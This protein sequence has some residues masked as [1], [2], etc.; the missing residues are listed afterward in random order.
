MTGSGVGRGIVVPAGPLA[1]TIRPPG[2]KSETNR[3]LV[4]AALADGD[5]TVRDV[6]VADDTEAMV[7]GLGSLGVELR[8]RPDPSGSGNA[9]VAVVGCAGRPPGGG[10]INA[11]LSG[12]TSRFLIPVAALG[13]EPS[14]VDG[15]PPL[16][17]RPMGDLLDAVVSLG[18][19]VE[20]LEERGHLPVRVGDPRPTGG[21]VTVRGDVSSQFLS[22]LLLAGPCL[23][24]GLHVEVT[25]DLVSV[26]YVQLT[27]DAMARFGAVVDG[28]VASSLRVRPSGY[29]AADVRVEADATAA[30]YFMAAPLIAGGRVRVE[31]VGS[32]SVQ[33]DA[34]F[35]DVLRRM[36]ADVRQGPDWTEVTSTGELYGIEVDLSDMSD[37]AQTLAV[38]AP[39]A[40]SPTTVRGIGFI[41]AKE[42][43]RIAAVVTELQ[44]LGVD[45]VARA[46]GFTVRPGRPVGGVVHTYGDH[47]MAMS[48][49]LIGLAVPG[50]V[51][52]DP[53]CV[54][55][56][57]PRFWDDLDRVVTDSGRGGSPTTL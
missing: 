53:G 5:S 11:R 31:G 10:L 52:A 19:G 47:R 44:R 21:R 38:L 50:V 22:G 54:D 23:A 17:S 48:F 45:A 40:S 30:S 32:A 4:C 42:T 24:E 27:V 43:D 46:D 16:R 49:S 39:F 35:A 26:P 12:T 33:G 3:L 8:V 56:T 37:T 25:S 7:D 51:I 9:D 2:S 1:A 18:G 14:L 15:E 13:E 55:K 34:A 36:G 29:A 28:D 20:S 6:L 57:Y 41:R